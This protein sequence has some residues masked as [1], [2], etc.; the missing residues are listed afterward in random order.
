[1]VLN[2]A[3]VFLSVA[4]V[5]QAVDIMWLNSKIAQLWQQLQQL[6]RQS[7]KTQK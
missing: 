2:I 4:V 7:E 3:R 1:M 6:Q 5:L